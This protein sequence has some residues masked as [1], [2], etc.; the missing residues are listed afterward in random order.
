VG[1]AILDVAPSYAEV[2]PSGC[3]LKLFFYVASE[4]VRRFLDRIGAQPHQWGVRRDVPGENSG[5]HGPAIEVY[6]SHR[7]FAVTGERWATTPDKLAMI[8]IESLK[9]LA[10]LLSPPQSGVNRRG[11]GSADNSRSAAAFRTGLA[12]HRTGSSFEEFCAAVRTDPLTA[13][14]YIEKGVVNGGRELRRIWQRADAKTET[15]RADWIA[16]VQRDPRGEPRPNLYNVMV[17]LRADV[18]IRDL[19]ITTRCCAPRS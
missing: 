11:R 18:R 15:R 9:R 10:L 14:W 8:D 12:M 3:G 4:D 17:A 2:S 5:N 7:Y 6:F 19:F 16:Q 1:R 13:G